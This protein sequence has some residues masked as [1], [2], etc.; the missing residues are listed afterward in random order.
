M[1]DEVSG[2]NHPNTRV[3]LHRCAGDDNEQRLTGAADGRA[4]FGD[5]NKTRDDF[6]Q[7]PGGGRSR[8]GERKINIIT[9]I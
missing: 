5:G 6:G 7:S 2:E 4:A 9:I 3:A 1:F 8:P